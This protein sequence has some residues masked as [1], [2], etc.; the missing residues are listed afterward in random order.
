MRRNSW[1]LLVC[2]V[3]QSIMLWELSRQ[4]V[5]C[6]VW[7]I[8]I[9]LYHLCCALIW[10]RAYVSSLVEVKEELARKDV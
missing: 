6:G 8:Y 3:S 9:W 10:Y 2:A 5:R 4:C 1:L 7:N